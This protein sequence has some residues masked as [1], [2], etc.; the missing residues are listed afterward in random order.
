[1]IQRPDPNE[2]PDVVAPGEE[3]PTAP[4]PNQP[5]AP[6]ET[7]PERPLPTDPPN[8]DEGPNE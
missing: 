1:M 8:P 5:P 7:P 4:P 3:G 6:G 2:V